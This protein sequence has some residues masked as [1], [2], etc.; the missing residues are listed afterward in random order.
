MQSYSSGDAMAVH[1]QFVAPN[2]FATLVK[3][4]VYHLLRSDPV[5][6]RVLLV[7]FTANQRTRLL[8]LKREDFEDNLDSKVCRTK[9]VKTLPPWL[10]VHGTISALTKIMFDSSLDSGQRESEI[11][12]GT[13][14]LTTNGAQIAEERHI[15]IQAAVDN[16]QAILSAPNPNA[17]LNRY[18]RACDPR[19]NETRF[20]TW[21]YAYLA[22]GQ[23]IAVLYPAFHNRGRY[24]RGDP[25]YVRPFG[26]PG[27][28]GANSRSKMATAEQ[29][30]KMLEA[31]DKAPKLNKTRDEVYDHILRKS[32]GCCVEEIGNS[33]FYFHPAGE[34]FPTPHQLWYRCEKD[35][36]GR[37]GIKKLMRGE[38]TVRNQDTPSRGQYSM[39]STN[40]MERVHLDVEHT[41]E[42][43]LSYLGTEVK[44]RVSICIVRDALDGYALGI[45]GGNGVEDGQIYLEALF[46]TAVPKSLFG[47]MI[48]YPIKD[49]EWDSAGL[50]TWAITDRGPGGRQ[51]LLDRIQ[52]LG[53]ARTITPTQ[54]PQSNSPA[55]SKNSRKPKI[56]GI[57]VEEVGRLTTIGLLQK[58]VAI[59]IREN[60][61][62]KA[63]DHASNGQIMRG[64]V[65]PEAIHLDMQRRGRSD[66]RYVS[67]EDAVRMFLQPIKVEY[68]DGRLY[69]HNRPFGGADWQKCLEQYPNGLRTK[70]LTGYA[71]SLATR[72]IFVEVGSALV[73]VDALTRY[74]DGDEELY[75]SLDQLAEV[76]RAAARAETAR[77]NRRPAEIGLAN[78]KFEDRTGKSMDTKTVRGARR[79]NG[80]NKETQ[81]LK[82]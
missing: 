51:A 75:L 15:H 35:R 57:P 71:L 52:K 31:F 66:A 30:A 32:Y 61:S 54:S 48:G 62:A 50:P 40:I 81:I 43:P 7:A 74:R 20:R 25:K 56:A 60:R 21:F 4:E 67:V 11:D 73:M 16:V 22:F 27:T 80:S 44:P 63:L 78:T 58:A 14:E 82:K 70:V 23:N 37:I 8:I 53:I 49:G 72:H 39:G 41:E 3:D 38:E 69:L 12:N 17:E 68:R 1:N 79:G 55:E 24:D 36:G 46:C 64:E 10:A 2:G 76:G 42:R 18:A 65:T 5:L 13:G 9:D 33:S 6:K 47:R 34:P 26:A 77:R 29:A 59:L 45:G 19:Q 28:A